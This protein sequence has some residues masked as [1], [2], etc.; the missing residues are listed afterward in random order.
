[1]LRM[2]LL[3]ALS[4]SVGW[5]FRGDYGHET[6]A[7]LPGA[8]LGLSIAMAAGR[9]DWQRRSALIALFCGLGW[10]IGGQ[11]SYGIV[12]GYTKYS[13]LADV[14][15]GY[16]SLFAIGALWGGIGAGALGIALTWPRSQLASFAWPL[17][18]IGA[19]WFFLDFSGWTDYLSTETAPGLAGRWA[20][21]DVD[22]VAAVSAL[23]TSL[24]CAAVLRQARGASLV[25][26]LLAAGWLVGF[27]VLTDLAGLRM[28]PPRSDNWAGTAG[29]FVAMLA[30][31]IATR[32]RATLVLVSSGLLAGGF[33]FAIGDFW[34]TLGHSKWGPLGN[35]PALNVINYWKVMEQFFGLLMG[36]GVALGVAALVRGKLAPA[37]DDRPRSAIDLTA[38]IFLL[39]VAPWTTIGQNVGFWQRDGLLPEVYAGV[40]SGWWMLAAGCLVASVIVYAAWKL[41][42]GELPLAPASDLGRAQ[43]LYLILLWGFLAGDFA[44]NVPRFG[45]VSTFVVHLS[46]WFTAGLASLIVLSIG[47]SDS[48]AVLANGRAADDPAWRISWRQVALW[49]VV[50]VVI[51]AVA[52]TSVAS[53]EGPLRGS[54][55]RFGETPPVQEG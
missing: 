3:S 11:M 7:I 44:R 52:Q 18:A 37:D 49:L 16:A 9:R 45:N 26:A 42:H 41:Q 2:V 50:P 36:L 15:Y 39:V 23:A 40:S 24:V 4:M 29:L 43:W 1:M 34:Q 48:D 13:E 22:W 35:W 30:W 17:I 47:E 12:I 38:L 8:L 14:A 46:F 28:T 5:G 20:P 10:A 21:Y 53:H 31:L 27:A 6:G 54:R 32:Q 51:Y 33:G 19:V 25:L 55:P